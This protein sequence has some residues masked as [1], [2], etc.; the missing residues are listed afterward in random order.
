MRNFS[1]RPACVADFNE[2][3]EMYWA[4]TQEERESAGVHYPRVGAHSYEEVKA[5]LQ[6]SFHSPYFH[7]EIVERDSTTIGFA[8][9]TIIFRNF[10]DPKV[11][12]RLDTIYLKPHARTQF[13]RAPM[14]TSLVRAMWAWGKVT[15]SALLPDE[16]DH[17]MEGAY[18]PGGESEK[19]W[20]AAGLKPY[21]SMCAWITNEGEADTMNMKRY[22]EGAHA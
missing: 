11:V 18:I 19:L 16:K 14:C 9:G 22:L 7:A 10:G 13:S 1:V 6:A 21:L 5:S 8:S 12:M 15:L 2:I 20:R 4:L 17:V 3:L